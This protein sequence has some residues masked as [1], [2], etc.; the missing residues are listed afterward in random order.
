MIDAIIAGAIAV[1]WIVG[2]GAFMVIYRWHGPFKPPNPEYPSPVED[3]YKVAAV[4]W[5]FTLIAALGIALG[6]RVSGWLTRPGIPEATPTADDYRSR[7][8]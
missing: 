3:G 6:T 1:A 7:P 4:F 5:P 8:Q 2:L